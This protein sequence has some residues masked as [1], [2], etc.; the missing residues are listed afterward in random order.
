MSQYLT[1]DVSDLAMA[2]LFVL[3]NAALSVWLGLGLTR[4]LI[5]AAARMCVQLALV[6]LVLKALFALA[7]G[8]LVLLA[9]AVMAAFA[10]HEV[11][12]R[13][14]RPLAGPW[15]YGLGAGS[16]VL[17]GGL[18]TIIALTT[19][20]RPQPW[21]D[22][23]FAIPLFG[24]I[25]GNAMTGV[26][27][28]LNRLADGAARERRAIEA[29]L[30]LGA[31]RWSAMRAVARDALLAGFTPILNAMAAT[32]VISLP[33]MMTGQILSGVDPGEAVKYQLL[34]MFLIAGATGIGVLLAV[35]GGIWRLSDERDRLRLDR[36]GPPRQ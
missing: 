17:A 32:G 16:M 11:R 7:S 14:K 25:L 30:L 4:Q 10:A 22:A 34:V 24:M 26:A 3:A 27:L 18:V 33:G 2:S 35:Y 36:L 12:S 5:V 6:A 15:G 9:A 31:D 13:Q 19:Q 21:F 20:I 8:P 28:G 1:L 29:R 23:R